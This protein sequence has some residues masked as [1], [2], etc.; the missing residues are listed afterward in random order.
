[1]EG[2]EG[3]IGMSVAWL[4]VLL[5]RQIPLSVSSPSRGPASLH[6]NVEVQN[7]CSIMALCLNHCVIQ[8]FR[9]L[10]IPTPVQL[11]CII[12]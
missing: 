11:D 4:T 10:F 7:F 8:R 5:E 12:C 9:L 1:M 6:A 2:G 3:C